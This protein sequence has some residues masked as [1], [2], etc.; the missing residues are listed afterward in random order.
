MLSDIGI[1]DDGTLEDPQSGGDFGTLF[2]RE[3]NTLLVN[4]RVDPIAHGARRAPAA[5]AHR[6]RREEPLLPARDGRPHVHAHR[7]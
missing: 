1:R 7:R 3:G 2:G 5:L 6:E 4:G